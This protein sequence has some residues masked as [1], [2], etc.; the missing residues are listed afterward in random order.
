[1]TAG[2]LGLAWL[3]LAVALGLLGAV[4]WLWSREQRMASGLP[5][6]KVV[7]SDT[8][9]WVRQ[10]RPIFSRDLGLVGR[11]DY[12]VRQSDGSW[13]PVEVKSASAPSEPYAGHVLQLAAYCALIGHEFGRR[14]AFGILQYRDRA[15]AIDFSPVLED[16]LMAL[17]EEMRADQD[18]AD[19]GRD[20]DD[21]RKC[22][23]CRLK[24]DC[25]EQL[26]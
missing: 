9:A 4:A 3:G 17:L 26:A 11:P 25:G 8:G 15:F 24:D 10:E 22:A 5:A 23:A 19:V 1:M 2:G 14:P 21:W 16:E 18:A 20:H 6:G 13:V 7:Y 12:V